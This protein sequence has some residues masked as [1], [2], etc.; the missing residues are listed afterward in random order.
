MDATILMISMVITW[1]IGMTPPLLIRYLLVK[2]PL[3]KKIS[4]AIIIIQWF[5]NLMIFTAL[6]SQSKTHAVLYIMAFIS[7]RILIKDKKGT[8]VVGKMLDVNKVTR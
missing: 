2:K 4:I 6:G 1:G 3:E 5:V 8:P 7:Y